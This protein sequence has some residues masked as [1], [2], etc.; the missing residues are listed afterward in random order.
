MQLSFVLLCSYFA[1]F[2]L[3]FFKL[4]SHLTVSL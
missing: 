1:V 4:F 3:Q 2:P